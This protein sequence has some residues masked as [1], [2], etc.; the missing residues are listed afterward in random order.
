M[1]ETEHRLADINSGLD[2]TINIVWNEIKY[3]AVLKKNTAIFPLTKCNPG[4]LNQVFMNMLVNAAHAIEKQGEITV[5]TWDNG[6]SIY[7]SI[8]DTGCG[9]PQDKLND[10][11]EPFLQLKNS[12]KAPGLG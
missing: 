11:F 6:N 10:I 7:I 12:V 3:K 1:D 2:S 4:Q 5:K 8:S 9:I